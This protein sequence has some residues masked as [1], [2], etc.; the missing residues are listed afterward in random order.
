[1]SVELQAVGFLDDLVL[2]ED[3][4]AHAQGQGDRIRGA[5]VDDDRLFGRRQWMR[6]KK[7]LLRTS[8]TT[9]FSMPMRASR[10]SS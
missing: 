2:D 1:L 8:L 5:G 4:R 3:G 9:I 6:A 10:G 7:V